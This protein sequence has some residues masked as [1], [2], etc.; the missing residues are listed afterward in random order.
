M[1][2]IARPQTR[3]FVVELEVRDG[4]DLLAAA[5]RR[6]LTL[7]EL[8]ENILVEALHSDLLPVILGEET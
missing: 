1:K 5:Q 8:M 6:G 2:H 3:R 7:Q 4:D